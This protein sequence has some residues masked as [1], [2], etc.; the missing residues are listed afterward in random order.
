MQIGK[1]LVVG[2]GFFE[3]SVVKICIRDLEQG[4]FF[5]VAIGII[6]DDRLEGLDGAVV[7]YIRKEPENSATFEGLQSIGVEFVGRLDLFKSWDGLSAR[8]GEGNS[9]NENAQEERSTSRASLKSAWPRNWASSRITASN[10]R[11][12]GRVESL[13]RPVPVANLIREV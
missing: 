3:A 7:V 12:S 1:I 10:A 8:E 9:S 13:R 5:V 11:T 6:V 2:E 4:L